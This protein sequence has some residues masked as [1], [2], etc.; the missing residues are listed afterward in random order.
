MGFSEQEKQA[1]LGLK[2]VGSTVIE[3]LEQI[4]FASLDQLAGQDP[5]SINQAVAQ[6][7]RASC[8]ANS[9]LARSAI[10]AVVDL[11]N[12]RRGP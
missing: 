8:W 2:G 11:A 4:G 10:A 12:A 7:L 9:P 3:R 5:R 1:M 6:M